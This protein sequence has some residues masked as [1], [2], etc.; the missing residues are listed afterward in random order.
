M[1][2]HARL[3]IG[4]L[5]CVLANQAY[6][7]PNAFRPR[8]DSP[9][10]VDANWVF[11]IGGDGQTVLGTKRA[12]DGGAWETVTRIPDTELAGLALFG[13]RMYLTDRRQ[14]ALYMF[15]LRKRDAPAVAVHIGAPLV[16]PGEIVNAGMLVV[17]DDEAR[18]LFAINIEGSRAFLKRIPG[19]YQLSRF[20]SMGGWPGELLLADP[21]T[22]SIQHLTSLDAESGPKISAMQKRDGDT[23]PIFSKLQDPSQRPNT[24][25]H[26]GYP[27][28][29]HPISPAAFNGIVYVIEGR[30]RQIFAA[31]VHDSRAVRL[32]LPGL[33]RFE[34]TRLVLNY[35]EIL[36]L[37]G[38]SG[39]LMR[40]PRQIPAEIR[41]FAK[42]DEA[43]ARIHEYLARRKSLPVRTTEVNAPLTDMLRAEGISPQVFCLM[44]APLCAA[45]APRDV[46][47]GSRIV[48]PG[49]YTER[50][51]TISRV[52]LDGSKT[53]GEVVAEQVRSS[54][55]ESYTTESHLR[56]TNGYTGGGSIRELREGAFRVPREEIRYLAAFDVTEL[57]RGD[58]EL[59]RLTDSLQDSIRL[60]PLERMAAAKAAAQP[61][62]H[63]DD[64]DCIAAREA[65]KKLLSTI[66]YALPLGQK[67]VTIGVAEENPDRRHLDFSDPNFPVFRALSGEPASPPAQPSPQNPG[68]EPVQWRKYKE[69]DHATAV[70]SLIA[71]RKRPFAADPLLDR[72]QI[73]P[74]HNEDPGLSQDIE[75][76]MID[77]NASVFNLSLKMLRGESSGLLAAI[78]TNEELATFVVSAG[79]D[80]R[81]LCAPTLKQYPACWGNQYKNLIVVGGT[82][83]DGKTI[84]AASNT[85]KHVQ[86]LAPAGGF[87][88]AGRDNGYVMVEGTSFATPLVTVTA[89]AL[90]AAGVDKPSLIKQ[91]ILATADFDRT[92]PEWARRLNVERAVSHLDFAVTRMGSGP[93]KVVSLE[94]E[95]QDIGF[96]LARNGDK[97]PLTVGKVRRLLRDPANQARFILAYADAQEVLHFERVKVPSGEWKFSFRNLG[98]DGQPTGEPIEGDL[99]E[100]DDYVGPI[101]F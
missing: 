50:A 100:F 33:D 20:T 2:A 62:A 28:V 48:L 79:N 97:L 10:V 27:G 75:R 23:G 55:F 51:I 36:A 9:I 83:L 12:G 7:Q 67:P 96:I 77:T 41:V 58:S 65:F 91:R 52:T 11:A 72:V 74:L 90:S 43:L 92:L 8:P 22:G 1:K 60:I 45:G 15:D 19:E 31:A 95:G 54:Q 71:A 68:V 80:G 3:G 14:R 16:R 94:N 26:E 53:L 93:V 87:F 32:E 30:E 82:N 40:W 44:N 49:L 73:V 47:S 99:A 38:R 69:E 5:L 86:I 42:P 56:E 78:E 37:E 6:A 4:W 101:K 88:A 85:G 59:R 24:L 46:A 21:F 63:P 57:Q 61:A 81:D 84:H 29:E 66:N 17:A 89:A 25:K 76:T 70:I 64:P 98:E 39:R 34:P 18:S 35:V 13:E